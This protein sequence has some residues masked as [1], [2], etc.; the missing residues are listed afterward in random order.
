[1]VSTCSG[2]TYDTAI[3][4]FQGVGCNNLT[5]EAGNDDACPNA[6]S[7]V[8]VEAC[9]SSDY[10]ILVHGYGIGDFN[11]TITSKANNN[12][13]DGDGLLDVCDN[14]PLVANPKQTDGDGDG[15]GDICDNCPD[16]PNGDQSDVDDDGIGDI[17]D[18]LLVRSQILC[19]LIHQ[20]TISSELTNMLAAGQ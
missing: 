15:V 12:D 10:Y 13:T 20:Y 17:C 2:A 19:S 14:C 3:S 9:E 8:K 16:T 4:V 18:K 5:C 11:L 1:M 6:R 7:S